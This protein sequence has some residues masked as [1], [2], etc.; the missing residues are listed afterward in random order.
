MT[1]T[2]TCQNCGA[3]IDRADNFCPECGLRAAHQ[4]DAISGIS[5]STSTP[6]EGKSLFIQGFPWIFGI[7]QVI[8]LGWL[9]LSKN[10]ADKSCSYGEDCARISSGALFIIVALWVIVDAIL[11][12]VYLH[13][14]KTRSSANTANPRWIVNR[15]FS[16]IKAHDHTRAW[17]LGG[18]N[19]MGDS[20]DSY[21]DALSKV[22]DLTVTIYSID[23]DEVTLRY[24][25]RLTDG[26]HQKFAGTYVV[27]DGAIVE[28]R[29][30]TE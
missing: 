30:A 10:Y 25:A 24:D 15:Y 22:S 21:A 12:A 20:Y 17:Q 14:K 3:S 18:K 27:R 13:R 19:L 26:A 5:A 4:L 1:E 6:R 28:A 23:G 16:A 8:F 11:V 7:V 29:P 2:A 9:L